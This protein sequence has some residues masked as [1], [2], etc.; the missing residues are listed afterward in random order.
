[1][2]IKVYK[3][4]NH[5]VSIKQTEIQRDWMDQTY[6]RHAYK[7][8]PISL[9]NTIGW[10]ISFSEDIE[11]IWDGISDT[12]PNHIKI[13]KGERLCSLG[14]ANGTISFNTGLYFKTGKN[15]SILSIVPPNYFIKGATPFTSIMSTSFYS[16]VFPV[17][18]KI[19]QPDELITIK[20]GTPVATIIPMSIAEVSSAELEIYDKEF[21]ESVLKEKKE[22]LEK[23]KEISKSGEFSN[24]Y[25]NATD[26]NNIKIGSHE[27]KSIKLKTTDFT[28]KGFKNE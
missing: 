16:D 26:H 15:I 4:P 27:V 22:Y 17:S 11:F 13:I 5:P 21:D 25:R 20:A 7:C 10:S 1:M 3:V 2:K 19:T 8:F 24:F 14:R 6:D 9:A 12:T 23:F 18:W 28:K